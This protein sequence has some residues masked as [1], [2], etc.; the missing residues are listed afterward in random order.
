MAGPVFEKVDRF[1]G[2][3]GNPIGVKSYKPFNSTGEDYLP[4]YLGMD[5]IPMDIVPQFPIE[6]QTV[7]LTEQASFD[8]DIVTKI[9]KQLTDGKTVVITTGL[10]KAL[11]GKLDEIVELQYTGRTVSTREFMGGREPGVH[12]SD[13]DILVPEITFFTNDSGPVISASTSAT[14]TSGVPILHRA[15]YSKGL[16]YVLTVPQAQGDLYAYPQPVLNTIREVLGK[17]MYVRLDAPSRVSLFVYDN[18]K[19]IV[20]SFQEIPVPTA[21]VITDKR[22]TK[23]RDMLTG[24]VLEGTPQGLTTVFNT[25]LVPGSYRVFSAE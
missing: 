21:R 11:K 5:G 17:Q 13:T 1:I 12:K 20:E 23:L 15:K 25:P 8:P 19:F 18:D 9:K 16:L 2:Q 3:L 24:Q 4:S 10:L 14:R 6:A 22:I 7:L